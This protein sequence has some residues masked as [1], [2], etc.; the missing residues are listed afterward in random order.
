MSVSFDQWLTDAHMPGAGS[1][2]EYQNPGAGADPYN[3][4]EQ[5]NGQQPEDASVAQGLK[6]KYQQATDPNNG[7]GSE[8]L[9]YAQVANGGA[10]TGFLGDQTPITL[11][12][13][14]YF[15]VGNS[16][17]GIMKD[18]DSSMRDILNKYG[19]AGKLISK[20]DQYGNL[21]DVSNPAGQRA[22]QEMSQKQVGN[23]NRDWLN[24]NIAPIFIGAVSAGV[25]A[26]GAGAAAAGAEGAAAGGTEGAAYGVGETGAF[27]SGVGMN[28]VYD[29]TSPALEGASTPAAY[30]PGETGAF[31]Q[32]IGVDKTLQN[33]QSPDQGI[34]SKVMNYIKDKPVQSANTLSKLMQMGQ[35][36][37]TQTTAPSA[38]PGSASPGMIADTSGLN[39][40]VRPSG[41]P[42]KTTS[43]TQAYDAN[44]FLRT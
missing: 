17:D 3:L 38:A 34:L 13:K 12:G 19:G 29:Y 15:R 7:Y 2:E 6:Q 41:A 8:G 36:G 14:T 18:P 32:G 24:N 35:S 16:V 28:G 26:L 22:Y 31:D 10:G 11:N 25:G 37:Q 43:G 30:A 9:G 1:M 23:N 27:D 5:F 40:G 4:R 20:N 42:L 44:G 33:Y 39:I 21:L